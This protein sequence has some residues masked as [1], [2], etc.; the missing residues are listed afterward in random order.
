M[1]GTMTTETLPK[2]WQRH[3]DF[4]A[5]V[6]TRPGLP[7]PVDVWRSSDDGGWVAVVRN[8]GAGDLWCGPFGSLAHALYVGETKAKD[9]RARVEDDGFRPDAFYEVRGHALRR[10]CLIRVTWYTTGL[11]IPPNHVTCAGGEGSNVWRLLLLE[12]PRPSGWRSDT[13]A[14]RTLAWRGENLGPT[15]G[16]RVFG[17]HL[18]D[19]AEGIDCLSG[20]T[21]DR[22]REIVHLATDQRCIPELMAK[23]RVQLSSPPKALGTGDGDVI[24]GVYEEPAT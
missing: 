6:Y 3:P 24:D 2:G 13:L 8:V 14:A 11:V 17:E 16:A 19:A 22:L 7:H 18:F 5:G 9:P 20:P 15:T 23:L 12:D 4:V 10:G 21:A 1:E